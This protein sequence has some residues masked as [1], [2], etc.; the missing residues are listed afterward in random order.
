MATARSSRKLYKIDEITVTRPGDPDPV[1]E[2]IVVKMK[3]SHADLLGLEPLP[4]DDALLTGT[5]GGSGENAGKSYRRRL[6][7]FRELP[8]TLEAKTEF[9]LTTNT[10]DPTVTEETTWKTITIGFPKGASVTEVIN[11][12]LTLDAKSQ[13]NALIT[14]RGQRHDFSALVVDP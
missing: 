1:E 9:T 5:F 13:I 3:K 7:G 14:P 6:G 4:P 2:P 10:D 12:L 8:F 11:W